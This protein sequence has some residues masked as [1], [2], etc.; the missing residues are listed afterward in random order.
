VENVFNTVL[1]QADYK[2]PLNDRD[3][4]LFGLQFTH[5]NA[6]NDGGNADP[7][8][9]YFQPDGQSNIISTQAGWQKGAW[10]TLAAYTHVTS[11]GRFLSP[12]EWGREP[13]YTFMLRER[14]EGSGNV[15]A[16]T[17][18]GIWQPVKSPWRIDVAYGHFYL[19]DV[20]N[21]ALNKYAFPAFNQL[22]TDVRYTFGGALKGLR[23][24]LVFVWKGRLGDVYGNDKY[25]INKVEMTHY[26]LILNYTF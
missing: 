21:A 23:A 2:H 6:V 24:Q 16:A 14:I 11:D 1:V 15:H 19:P 13:F 5:Q 3:N 12:R 10:T 26:N 9:T 22:A 20:K 8:M 18:R 4:L 7:E 25:V 17:L